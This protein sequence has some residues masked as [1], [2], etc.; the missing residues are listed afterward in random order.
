M[1][2]RD[3]KADRAPAACAFPIL[4]GDTMTRLLAAAMLAA[5]LGGVPAAQA[6]DKAPPAP[7]RAAPAKAADKAADVT[8]MQMLRT[9][10]QQDKKSFVAS[11]LQLTDAEGKKFWPIYDAYQRTLDA[12][13]RRRNKAV[14]D[15]VGMDRPM[16]DLY[17]RNL[18]TELIQA[19]ESEIKARRALQNKLMRALPPRKAARYLQLEAKIRAVEAYE[20]AAALP[21]VK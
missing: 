15:I 3:K 1:R 12:A 18:A 14:I 4:S 9:A 20:V 21:L 13:D 2:R 5:A 16:S 17:A 7:D 8:D 19:D 6:A 11:T 10:V